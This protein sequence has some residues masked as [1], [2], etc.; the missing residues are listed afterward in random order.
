MTDSADTRRP[1]PPALAD[2]QVARPWVAQGPQLQ[3]AFATGSMAAGIVFV[4]RIV[5]AAERRGHHPDIMLRYGTVV[6]TLSTWSAGGITR[7]DLELAEEISTIAIELDITPTA[8]GPSW[9]EI[10]I[11]ALD[12]E[13]VKEFWRSTFELRAT[14]RDAAEL[15]DPAGNLPTIWFQQ[16][17]VPRR[18]RNRVHL[19]IW[20]PPAEIDQRI[21]AALAAGGRLVSDRQAPSFWVLAD[22][23][24]NEVCLCTSA[25]RQ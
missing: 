4:D 12:L 10:A 6:L 21:A 14:D 3:A 2:R 18:Q 8:N 25:D 13:R 5:E 7:A 15:V 17:D 16:M 11:D 9:L 23:E 19:D 1:I 24:G 22:P 20:V